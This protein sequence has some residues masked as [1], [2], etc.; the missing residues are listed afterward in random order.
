MS[1]W[2]GVRLIISC[3]LLMLPITTRFSKIIPDTSNSQIR[4]LK[5]SDK[6]EYRLVKMNRFFHLK[7]KL[8]EVFRV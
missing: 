4:T 3:V 8:I 5:E 1:T 6:L 2:L 7:L